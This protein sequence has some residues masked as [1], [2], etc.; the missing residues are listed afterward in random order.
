MYSNMSNTCLN[1]GSKID[2]EPFNIVFIGLEDII[3]EIE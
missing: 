2:G 1:C 3:S